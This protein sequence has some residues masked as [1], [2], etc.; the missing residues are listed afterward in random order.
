[1][2]LKRFCVQEIVDHYVHSMLMLMANS[3]NMVVIVFWVSRD[4]AAMAPVPGSA[5]EALLSLQ[6]EAGPKSD[7][8]KTSRAA[9]AVPCQ[10]DCLAL[11]VV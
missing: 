2:Q 6:Q 11:R 4:F 7:W 9:A 3:S 8:R 10:Q 5:T 1:M